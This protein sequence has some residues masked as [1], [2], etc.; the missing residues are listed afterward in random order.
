MNEPIIRTKSD[1]DLGRQAMKF[2][3]EN[4][5]SWCNLEWCHLRAC[6]KP[7]LKEKIIKGE[8]INDSSN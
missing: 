2:V 8:P 7:E 6:E 1:A 5:M 4:C 3:K